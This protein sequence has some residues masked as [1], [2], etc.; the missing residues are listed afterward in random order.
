MASLPSNCLNRNLHNGMSNYPNW[1]LLLLSL[2]FAVYKLRAVPLIHPR[3]VVQVILDELWKYSCLWVN[4]WA[5]V[6]FRG[7]V[8]HSLIVHIM[9]HWN[10]ENVTL[11][12]CKVKVVLQAAPFAERGRVWSRRN[13]W[14][15]ATQKL[16]MTNQIHALCRSHPLSW[17]NNYITMC[18]VDVSMLLSNC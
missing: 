16:A 17:G 6:M 4:L 2:W 7:G 3:S 13:Y 10:F 8:E 18:L 14:V 5:V 15:V 1:Y 9:P 11:H 12:R